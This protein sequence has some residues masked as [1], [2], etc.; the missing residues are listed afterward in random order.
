MKISVSYLS[1]KQIANDLVKLSVTDVDYI[2]VD[3]MDGKFVKAKSLPFS[4]VSNIHEFTNKRLDVHLMVRKP[5]KFIKDYVSLNTEYIIIHP[6]IKEDVKSNLDLIKSYG[7]KCGLALSPDTDINVL[8]P[9]INDIDIV[10]LMSVVP[11][12]GGQ[13]FIEESYNK[14]KELKNYLKE[15]KV[16]PVISIDGGINDE[17]ASKLKGADIIVSGSYV[18]NS[19]DFQE[20]IDKLRK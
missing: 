18:I 20:S 1:S 11:G 7:I 13:P 19:N 5:K 2:H 8:D 4:E 14:L 9:Y 12:K 16:A 6:E 17:V 10:L 3:V 15:K